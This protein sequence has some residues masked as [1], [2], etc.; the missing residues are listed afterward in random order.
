MI[1]KDCKLEPENPSILMV[2]H[3][4]LIREFFQI[5]FDEMG[6]E[7][8]AGAEPGDHKKLARN[9]SWSRFELSICDYKIDTIKCTELCNADH[10]NGLD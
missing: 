3:G 6:C 10:L 1:E 4:G 9:T 5:L 7:L 8:P 2:T